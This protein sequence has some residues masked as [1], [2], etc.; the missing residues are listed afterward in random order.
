M[1]QRVQSIFL[2]L[3]AV[4]M[5]VALASPIWQKVGQQPTEL[6]QLSAI[7]LTAQKGITSYV[8][9]LWYL[10]A[11][12]GLVMGLSIYAITQ[13]KNRLLQTGLCAG[14]ALLLTAIMGIII[15]QTLYLGKEYGNAADQGQFQTGFYAIIAALIC[16]ALANRFIRRDEKLVRE[17]DR[18]R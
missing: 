10:V 13:F 18:L 12:M 15:Y 17:S 6:A 7:Q 5:G 16:N 1:L 2:L 9:P 14:N 3:I 8:T 11:L 4:A